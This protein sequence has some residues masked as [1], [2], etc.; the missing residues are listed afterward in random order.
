M[1]SSYPFG[2]DTLTKAVIVA[3]KAFVYYVRIPSWS[4]GA[5]ISINGSSFDPCKPVNGLHA[6]RIEPG[7]TNVTLDLPLELVAGSFGLLFRSL[8]RFSACNRSAAPGTCHD[9]PRPSDLRLRRVVSVQRARRA[10]R[11]ALC[12]RPVDPVPQHHAPVI[13]QLPVA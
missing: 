5:T 1:N 11:S 6:I 9:T 13:Q 3:Q 12:D 10:P 4:A 7:T 8:Q 2:W